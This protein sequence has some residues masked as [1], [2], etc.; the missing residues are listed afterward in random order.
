LNNSEKHP[1]IQLKC[2][3][4]YAFEP[5]T[6]ISNLIAHVEQRQ[7]LEELPAEHAVLFY[8]SDCSNAAANSCLRPGDGT[9]ELTIT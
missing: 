6:N 3:C 4:V 2:V 5:D 9:A 8:F 7:L 1:S